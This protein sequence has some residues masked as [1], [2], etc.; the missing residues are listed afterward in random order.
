[1]WMCMGMRQSTL[2]RSPRYE[3]HIIW[4]SLQSSLRSKHIFRFRADIVTIFDIRWCLTYWLVFSDITL[5]TAAHLQLKNSREKILPTAQI[6]LAKSNN[7]TIKR[8]QN[9]WTINW[10]INCM[11]N[12]IGLRHGSISRSVNTLKTLCSHNHLWSSPWIS[13]PQ[14]PR[15]HL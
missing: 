15:W 12:Q 10:T 7:R 4:I 2:P 13:V 3:S 6:G 5:T 1:M 9:H 8:T 14:S 11:S